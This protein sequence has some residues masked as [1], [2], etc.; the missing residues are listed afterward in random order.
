MIVTFTSGE[1]DGGMLCHNISVT[2]DDI[3]ENTETYTVSLT[4]DD[5]DV[6]ITIPTSS[7]IILDQI[8][9]TV[10]VLLCVNSHHSNSI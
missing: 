8:D 3:L 10:M 5:D 7:M 1:S 9:G 4:S 2:D 6:T